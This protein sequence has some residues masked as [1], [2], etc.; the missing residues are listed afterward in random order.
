M[1]KMTTSVLICIT[2]LFPIL[3]VVIIVQFYP[4]LRISSIVAAG[5]VTYS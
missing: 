3:K 5:I 2:N 1:G 4:W